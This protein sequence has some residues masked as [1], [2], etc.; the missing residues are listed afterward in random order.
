MN[1]TNITASSGM[2]FNITGGS[3]IMNNSNIVA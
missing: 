3:L 2:I 1:G